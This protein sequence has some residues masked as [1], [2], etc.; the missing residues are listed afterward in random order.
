PKGIETARRLTEA[1]ELWERYLEIYAGLGAERVHNPADLVEHV[2]SPQLT[3]ALRARVEQAA[4]PTK[5]AR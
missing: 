4:P 3:E 1:H 5:N 2:L